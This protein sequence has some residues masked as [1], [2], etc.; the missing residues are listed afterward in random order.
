MTK[1]GPMLDDELAQLYRLA[2]LGISRKESADQL[3]RDPH[4]RGTWARQYDIV[5]AKPK[6]A[7]VRNGKLGRAVSPSSAR[8]P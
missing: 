3:E 2:R 7:W 8:L 6:T 4:T 1:R 5:I